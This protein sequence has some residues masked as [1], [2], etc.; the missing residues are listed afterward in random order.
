M[1]LL[2]WWH[3]DYHAWSL[4]GVREYQWRSNLGVSRWGRAW[5]FFDAR[6]FRD[7][8]DMID[9]FP[10]KHIHLCPCANRKG[11]FAMNHTSSVHPGN[12]L[13]QGC[14]INGGSVGVAKLE[15]VA[16]LFNQSA[17][18]WLRIYPCFMRGEPYCCGHLS[19]EVV[20]DDLV[21]LIVLIFYHCFFV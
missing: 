19:A 5:G 8:D 7:D 10:L 1:G 16:V 18:N 20:W 14:E 2:S 15:R 17:T 6:D 21:I 4:E 12:L 13:I 11:T 3:A 9:I